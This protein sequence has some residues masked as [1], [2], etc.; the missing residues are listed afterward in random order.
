MRKTVTSVALVAFLFA[1]VACA[2][3]PRRLSR[4]WD[5]HVN[6]KYTEN[7]WVHGALLQDVLPVY[8]LVGFVA[9]IGD[10]FVN[11]Y[12]FWGEDAWDNR[13]TGFEHVNPQGAARTVQGSGL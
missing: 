6:Q 8:G 10:G 12:Y 7:A 5:D 13:G 2:S 3:G 9:A 11:M 4:A 1:F